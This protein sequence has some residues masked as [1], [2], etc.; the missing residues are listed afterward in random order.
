MTQ[1]W[2]EK[3]A[4]E[5]FDEMTEKGP[6]LAYRTEHQWCTFFA[7]H[8]TLA[9]STAPSAEAAA[10]QM[11][12]VAAKLCD[13]REEELRRTEHPI[14]AAWFRDMAALI[15]ALPTPQP[16]AT[17]SA[18]WD[19]GA[20]AMREAAVKVCKDGAA[21]A[22]DLVF[23]SACETCAEVIGWLSLSAPYVV[24]LP[25]D[26]ADDDAKVDCALPTP[27]PPTLA[28][29]P[30]A[31]V[32]AVRCEIETAIRL[33]LIKEHND[34]LRSFLARLPAPEGQSR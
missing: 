4:A 12:E 22:T 33:G 31:E 8:L 13:T 21:Q 34:L 24:V 14:L 18:A 11:R 3:A 32:S 10:M 5:M 17:L 27:Q 23:G 20:T 28:D 1:A 7:R 9:R 30:A 26:D 29:V 2:A 15:R 19:A 16:P 25:N 6:P